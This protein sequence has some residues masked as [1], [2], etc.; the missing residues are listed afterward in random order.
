MNK[1]ILN[2]V[3]LIFCL[4]INTYA[5]QQSAFEFN[6]S[7]KNYNAGKE[8][9]LEFSFKEKK[10]INL[11]IQNSFGSTIIKGVYTQKNLV[12]KVPK[13]ISKKSGWVHWSLIDQ[14]NTGNFY[15]HPQKNVLKIETYLGP[16]SL[17]AG[18]KEQSMFVVVPVDSLN[19]PAAKNTAIDIHQSYINQKT[20]TTILFDGMIGYTWIP[21]QIKAG[22]LFLNAVCMDKNTKELSLE[23]QPNYPIN[24]NIQASR[25]HE[26]ADGNQ[27]VKFKTSILKDQYQNIVA[28]GTSVTFHITNNLN[29]TFITY[30][31]TINGIAN[32][33]I[34]HPESSQKWKIQALVDGICQSNIINLNFKE[35][36]NGFKIEYNSKKLELKIGPFKSFMD[37]FIPDGLWVNVEVYQNKQL[38]VELKTQTEN[39]YAY[40]DLEHYLQPANTYK[41]K[42]KAANITQE[43]KITN[44]EK[45]Q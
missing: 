13:F 7:N 8:I 2:I 19:N 36:I 29:Q 43:L 1:K 38:I 23:I 16:P 20:K 21:S 5:Q 32:A 30:G 45:Q 37:Q 39:G 9:K 35:A 14:P 34:T 42:V 10:N 33:N 28:N 4:G 3:F 27:I 31:T 25:V 18:K 41:V 15:I 12:F 17:K 26:F 22:R 44:D 40:L 11:Y 6:N 24:F